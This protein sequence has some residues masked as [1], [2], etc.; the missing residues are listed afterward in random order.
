MFRQNSLFTSSP[1]ELEYLEG[2]RKRALTPAPQATPGLDV[3]DVAQRV[4]DYLETR[5]GAD[6]E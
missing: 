1:E 4:A 5:P 6:K 2:V 3:E